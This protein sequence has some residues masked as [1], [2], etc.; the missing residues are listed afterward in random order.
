MFRTRYLYILLLSFLSSCAAFFQSKKN[1]QKEL[2]E[3]STNIPTV[4]LD[5]VD[6][7]PTT[8]TPEVYQASATKQTDIIHTKLEVSFDWTKQYLF[9]KATITARPYFYPQSTLVLDARGMEIKE[10]DL[11][12]TKKDIAVTQKKVKKT[13]KYDTTVTESTVKSQLKYTYKDDVL[14]ISLDKEYKHNEQYKVFF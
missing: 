6:I 10:V 1:A 12:S 3:T 9:G 5:T 8:P 11:L 13:I 4:R 2:V 14:T 7:K